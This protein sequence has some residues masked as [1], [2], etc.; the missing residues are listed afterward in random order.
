MFGSIKFIKW[1]CYLILAL[2]V[3]ST[4]TA[5]DIAMFIINMKND[6]TLGT[7]DGKSQYVNFSLSTWMNCASIVQFAAFGFLLCM[8]LVVL[9]VDNLIWTIDDCEDTRTCCCDTTDIPK[10]IGC[11]II[12]IG[13]LVSCFLLAWVVIGCLLWSEIK[14]HGVNNQQCDDM[15]LAWLIINI[16]PPAFL[17]CS[18]AC[19]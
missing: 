1:N 10:S 4:L 14:N 5:H 8:V 11:L 16:V 2:A 13:G 9:C 3:L 7:E 18:Y 15:L 17:V 6:C 12:P 19:Q